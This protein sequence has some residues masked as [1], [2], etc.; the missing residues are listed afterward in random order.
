MHIYFE[1]VNPDDY[2]ISS[3]LMNYSD[4]DVMLPAC[5][6]FK[7]LFGWVFY[8]WRQSRILSSRVSALSS[9]LQAE[10]HAHHSKTINAAGVRNYWFP[11]CSGCR[12]AALLRFYNE[13]F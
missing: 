4:T 1:I 13:A 6:E 2:E 10:L 5:C 8:L 7:N 12:L 9:V 3:C 11:V